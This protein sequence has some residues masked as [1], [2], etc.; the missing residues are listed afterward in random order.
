MPKAG[1][2]LQFFKF[3]NKFFD[4]FKFFQ[5]FSAFLEN[6]NFFVKFFQSTE[7]CKFSVVASENG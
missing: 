6:Q 7:K 5:N 4:R 1:K 3:S 2:K